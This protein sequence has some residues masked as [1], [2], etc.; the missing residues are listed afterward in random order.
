MLIIT[1]GR[2]PDIRF[3]M[4][5]SASWLLGGFGLL[6]VGGPWALNSGFDTILPP[7][8]SCAGRGFSFGFSAWVY[9]LKHKADHLTQS[10]NYSLVLKGL[11][12]VLKTLRHRDFIQHDL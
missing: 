2:T 11:T 3:V 10:T 7:D 9:T 4:A 8:K 12:S 1:T 5:A 6:S